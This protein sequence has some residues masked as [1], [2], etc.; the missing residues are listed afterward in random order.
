[1]AAFDDLDL[2]VTVPG[3]VVLMREAPKTAWAEV[4]AGGI[5]ARMS[6]NSQGLTLHGLPDLDPSELRSAARDAG[7]RV[8][9]LMCGRSAGAYALAD[10]TSPT[11]VWTPETGSGAA[12]HLSMEVHST[13]SMTVGGP[14]TAYPATWHPAMR[15]FRMSQTTGDLYDAFRNLYLALESVLSTMEQVRVNAKGAPEGEGAWIERALGTA[16]NSLRRSNPAMG[17]QSYLPARTPGAGATGVVAD[18]K[19]ELYR[20]LRTRVFHAKDG[21]PVALPQDRADQAHVLDGLVRYGRLFTDLAELQLGVRYLR[22]WISDPVATQLAD[23]SMS[24][25]E[26]GLSTRA[27]ATVANFEKDGLADLVILP[28]RRAPELDAARRS[29]V[30]GS[31]PVAGLPLTGRVLS[32][33]VHST[34]GLPVAFEDLGGRLDIDSAGE[35][36]V[37]VTWQVGGQGPKIA[38]DS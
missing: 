34:D 5:T 20:D 21:R 22:S 36:H 33:G 35:V 14:P 25:W 29:V 10:P 32:I 28:T 30:L 31:A 3:A 6:P 23:A 37:A 16:H 2:D 4:L 7:N 11:A 12:V 17:L 15:Y 24:T 1:V 38:Y 9:D 8:L 18:V 26:V 27:F 19:A 13:F